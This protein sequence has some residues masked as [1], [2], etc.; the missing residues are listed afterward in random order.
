MNIR[1]L[2]WALPSTLV[3]ALVLLPILIIS[4]SWFTDQTDVWQHLASTQLPTLIKNSFVLVIGVG[5]GVSLLGISLGWLIAM[6]EFPGRRWLE[7]ALML[8]LAI[9]PYILAFVVLGIFDFAGPVQSQWRVWFGTDAWFPQVRSTGGVIL[10]MTAVLYPYVYMLARSAFMAQGKETMDSARLLGFTPW[11]SFWKVALPMARPA[12]VAGCAL[13]LMET[14]A[15]FGTVA[16]FNYDTF[17]T[18]IYK[19]WLGFFN[20]QAAAQ[21]ASLLLLFVIILLISERFSRKGSDIQQDEKRP[22]IYELKSWK[23]WLA[24]LY[25]SG[26]WV[27]IFVIP[28]IKLCHWIALSHSADL[29]QHIALIGHSLLLASIAAIIVAFT[30]LLLSSAQH[31]YPSKFGKAANTITGF[32][33]ALPGSILAVGITIVFTYFDGWLIEQFSFI[34][35]PL[36]VGSLW[37][38]VVAY[39]IRFF[40]VGYGP[41]N[42]SVSRIKPSLPAAAQTLGTPSWQLMGHLYI[43]I[44][45]PGLLTACLLVF[46]DVMKEMPATLLMRPFGWDTLAV[47]IYELTSEGEWQ[48]AAFPSLTLVLIGLLPTLLII[49]KTRS[50]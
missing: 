21:L 24:T 7:W 39:G 23:A 40:T 17:T 6:C 22:A 29:T 16:I 1:S 12:I 8:P 30:A 26:L 48:R 50:A 49:R 4:F 42:S 13:A 45:M 10:V 37:A 38:L 33:Y 18:A 3:A 43:P 36:L 19:T 28:V 15:D 34:N 2:L 11:Q 5:I 47:R 9:P 46:V 31:F 44:L 14:L 32:G 25:C 27:L 35:K 41:I 20:L